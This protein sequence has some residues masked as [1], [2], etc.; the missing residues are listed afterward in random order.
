[1]KKGVPLTPCPND[2][3]CSEALAFLDIPYD[4]GVNAVAFLWQQITTN[5]SE[6]KGAQHLKTV[7]RTGEIWCLLVYDAVHFCEPVGTGSTNPRDFRIDAAQP[8]IRTEPN[9]ARRPRTLQCQLE[10]ARRDGAGQ[11]VVLRQCS[12]RIQHQCQIGHIARHW[13]IHPQTVKGRQSIASRDDAWARA[14]A[15]NAAEACR[16]SQRTA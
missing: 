1:M 9:A 5:V 6:K 10:A 7:Y 4:V 14:Q 15:H 16:D 8:E 12:H 2:F 3:V 13:T 11:R